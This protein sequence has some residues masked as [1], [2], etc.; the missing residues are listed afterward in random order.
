[1][2]VFPGEPTLTH[3]QPHPRTTAKTTVHHEYARIELG[4]NVYHARVVGP[5][6]KLTSADKELHEW[7]E[8]TTTQ[9]YC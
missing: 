7:Q 4:T 6:Q 3:A 1:M 2:R 5:D 8:Q 9:A